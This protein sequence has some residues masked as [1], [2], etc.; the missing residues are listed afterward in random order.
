MNGLHEIF[1][2]EGVQDF[3]ARE[4]AAPRCGYAVIQKLRQIA[5]RPLDESNAIRPAD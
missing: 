1:S 3:I 5:S 4:P 2:I